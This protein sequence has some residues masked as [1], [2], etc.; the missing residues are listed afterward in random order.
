M[1]TDRNCEAS[2]EAIQKDPERFHIMIAIYSIMIAY[3]EQ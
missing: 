3:V 2:A 1:I